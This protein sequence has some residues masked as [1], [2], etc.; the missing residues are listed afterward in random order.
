MALDKITRDLAVL[1]TN[2]TFVA[3]ISGGGNVD[4]SY[5]DGVEDTGN[6]LSHTFIGEPPYLINTKDI[7]EDTITYMNLNGNDL[8]TVAIGQYKN[9]QTLD[10]RNNNISYKRISRVLGDLDENGIEGGI[11]KIAGNNYLRSQLDEDVIESLT[12]KGWD[13]SQGLWTPSYISI[14]AWYDASD[15]D[16]ITNGLGDIVEIG[17]VVQWDDKTG[18]GYH[19]VEGTVSNQPSTGVDT[20]N[21]LNALTVNLDYMRALNVPANTFP[22]SI[23]ITAV[24]QKTGA[25]TDFEAFATRTI[26]GVP[27]PMDN[28]DNRRQVGNSGGTEYDIGFVNLNSLTSPTIISDRADTTGYYEWIDGALSHSFASAKYRDNASMILLGTRGDAVTRFRGLWGEFVITQG[29]SEGD[30]Q[31]VEGYLAH[32]W[33]LT[34][35]LPVSHPYKTDGTTFGY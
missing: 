6:N 16:T 8:S 5:G 26:G 11:V 25:P 12:S 27:A 32:K 31:K 15:L 19:M 23:Q 2:G 9:L 18:N 22:T 20:I 24:I 28:F 3:I 29:L 13:L 1:K 10:I 14:E 4:I 34:A 7:D 30:R 21:G 33:G 35:N 17:N